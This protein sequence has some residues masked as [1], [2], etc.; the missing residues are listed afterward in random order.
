[1]RRKWIITS[2]LAGALTLAA[3]PAVADAPL[4]GVRC[5]QTL[6]QSVKLYNDLTNCPGDGLVIGANDIRIDLNGHTIDG[7]SP[8]TSDC[9]RPPFGSAGI[10]DSG[11][12]DRV[13]VNNGTVQ[14][15]DT[16]LEGAFGHS[17]LTHLTVRANTFSGISIGSRKQQDVDANIIEHNVIDGNAC[18]G[19]I[20]LTGSHDSVIDDNRVTNMQNQES[21]AISL[22]FG[23]NNRVSHNALSGNRGDGI[24]LFFD[25]NDNRLEQNTITDG[26][27]GI[28]LAGPASNNEIQHNAI[29]RTQGPGI[30]IESADFAPGPPTGNRVAANSLTSV[31]DG[32]ILFEADHGE[33]TGNAVTGAG[34][35]GDPGNIGF[36]IL[37]DGTSH[38]VIGRNAVAG[39]RGP[40]ISIG[41]LDSSQLAPTGN[42]V[43]RNTAKSTISMGIEVIAMARDTTIERNAADGNGADGIHVLSPS[44]TIT[45]NSANSNAAY[46]IEAVIGVIDGGGN[47][48]QG[49]GNPAQCIGVT[50]K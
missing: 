14:E 24:G 34:M 50:C 36:G 16:G 1:M 11:G 48:A 13:T 26:G 42:V 3:S 2:V 33:L 18:R 28:H 20:A 17:S 22:V 47:K 44:T 10:S 43:S 40:A 21:A 19:G 25:A 32:I 49:N 37:L 30:V 9:N 29:A 35:F 23:G 15:F 31:G 12:F 8:A 39:G 46:G 45:R 4:T 38:S 6:T 27:S 5:G 41:V 7:V